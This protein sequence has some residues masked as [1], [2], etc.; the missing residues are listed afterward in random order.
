MSQVNHRGFAPVVF[1]T[2]LIAMLAVPALTLAA[3]PSGEWLGKAKN[4]DGDE[5]E[6][7]L[8]LEKVPGGWAATLTDETIGDVELTDILVT[9]NSISFRY[10]PQGVPFPAHFLGTYDPEEDQLAGTFAIRGSSRFVKFKRISG[11]DMPVA[12]QTEPKEPVRIRHDYR[13]GL[14]GRLSYWGAPHTVKD[15]TYNLNDVTS[16][17][18]GNLDGAVYLY[19]Q[20][21]FCLYGRVYRGGL[22]FTDDP[23]KLG[24]WDEMGISSESYLTLDGWDLGIRGFLGNKVFPKSNFNPYLI[25]GMGKVNWELNATGRGSEVLSIERTPLE[26]SDWVFNAGIG[27]EYELSQKL[28]LEFEWLWRYFRTEDDVLWADVDRNWSHTHA[29]VFSFGASYGLF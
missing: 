5:F 21:G 24:Q 15:E 10:Q 26:G 8:S 9:G 1:L 4:A 28:Q 29:W 19:I 17:A 7:T 12:A 11:G 22:N 20:D 16:G 14:N 2:A 18:G 25:G 6:I 27:C 13:L 23:D 3:D